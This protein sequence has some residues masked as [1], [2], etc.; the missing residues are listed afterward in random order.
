MSTYLLDFDYANALQKSLQSL[1][2]EYKPDRD[3]LGGLS[4]KDDQK[5]DGELFDSDEANQVQHS[6]D[7]E[8]GEIFFDSE[9]RETGEL[10]N[11]HS[12]VDYLVLVFNRHKTPCR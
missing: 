2:P 7:A 4:L 6:S 1:I 3:E 5:E 10:I 11:S 8:E 9:T 12:K